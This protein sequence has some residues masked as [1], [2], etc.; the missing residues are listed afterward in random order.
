MWASRPIILH[1]RP[2]LRGRVWE[3]LSAGLEETCG[4]PAPEKRGEK[5]DEKRAIRT[6][7]PDPRP[8]NLAQS[9][10]PHASPALPPVKGLDPSGLLDLKNKRK[11]R[12][13]GDWAG[14][15]LSPLHQR[16]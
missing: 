4:S 16:L 6:I 14:A 1:L 10:P 5:G 3:L 9:S 11:I 15:P 7:I 8:R 13:R 2:G 12:S